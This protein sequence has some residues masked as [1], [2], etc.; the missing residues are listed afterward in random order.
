MKG[1]RYWLW[2]MWKFFWI[3]PAALH[4]HLVSHSFPIALDTKGEGVRCHDTRRT[5]SC[6]KERCS[7]IFHTTT[8]DRLSKINDVS[9]FG[10]VD[11]RCLWL[12]APW[13]Y[14]ET[15]EKAVDFLKILIKE[16]LLTDTYWHHCW[17]A[18]K[19]RGSCGL[20]LDENILR[21]CSPAQ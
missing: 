8:V 6:P 9:D 16:S 13:K 5:R 17:S 3:L 15:F 11:S 2:D 1:F 12:W 7:N 20:L 21:M 19:G 10:L 4:P 18:N 14:Y